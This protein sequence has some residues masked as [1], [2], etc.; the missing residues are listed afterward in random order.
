M[1]LSIMVGVCNAVFHCYFTHLLKLKKKLNLCENFIYETKKNMLK[2]M[3]AGYALATFVTM[4]ITKE[5]H[6]VVYCIKSDTHLQ[7]K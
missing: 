7:C 6:S 1:H 5:N 3:L 2:R 4:L